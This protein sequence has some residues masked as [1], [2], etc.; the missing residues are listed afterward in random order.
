MAQFSQV[1]RLHHNL[2]HHKEQSNSWR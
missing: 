1:H 2:F